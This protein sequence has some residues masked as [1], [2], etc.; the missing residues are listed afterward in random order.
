MILKDEPE[1]SEMILFWRIQRSE[2]S[3]HLS[4]KS[5]E[6]AEKEREREKSEQACREDGEEHER[7]EK[8]RQPPSTKGTGGRSM[9]GRMHD[10]PRKR[11]RR[12][13]DREPRRMSGA[14]ERRGEECAR[15]REKERAAGV[16]A[17]ARKKRG[18]S[19]GNGRE[20]ARDR[21]ALSL[22][23]LLEGGGNYAIDS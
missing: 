3:D 19:G 15:G 4:T 22:P 12:K 13:V 18:G 9:E 21:R 5:D 14:N 7:G 6:Q 23:S 1:T 8:P 10:R 17:R 20:P 11:E 16:P 2:A